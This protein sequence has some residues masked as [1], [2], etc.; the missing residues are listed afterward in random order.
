MPFTT[1]TTYSDNS[2]APATH[3]EASNHC[4][5]STDALYRSTQASGGVVGIP[6]ADHYPEEGAPGSPE[7]GRDGQGNMTR[8]PVTDHRVYIHT[9]V[10]PR[11]ITPI[12]ATLTRYTNQ[13]SI[14]PQPGLSPSP[15]RG[16][17][18]PA[19]SQRGR[20][21]NLVQSTQSASNMNDDK[22]TEP[23]S[24]QTNTW[25]DETLNDGRMPLTADIPAADYH[26]A[27]SLNTQDDVQH[28][29][30][31]QTAQTQTQRHNNTQTTQTSAQHRND[32]KTKINF[33]SLNMSGSRRVT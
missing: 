3:G 10:S 28:H 18:E 22:H 23:Q 27:A 6:I 4:S 21:N 17:N 1:T 25:A 31:V 7:T 11:P 9:Y 12:L 19:P 16:A 26:S 2:H 33:A 29:N 24:G 8:H 32:R 20:P 30:G 13:T 5:M 14:T 15:T